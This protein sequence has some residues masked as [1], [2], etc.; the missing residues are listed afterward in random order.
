MKI[1]ESSLM[2]GVGFPAGNNVSKE[3]SKFRKISLLSRLIRVFLSMK[4][5]TA[6]K[7]CSTHHQGAQ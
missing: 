1:N 2:S 5:M 7:F 3:N 6:P 4:F